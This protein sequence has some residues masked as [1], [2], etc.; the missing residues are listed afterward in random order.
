MSS[1]HLKR[2]AKVAWAVALVPALC[3]FA[4]R[5]DAKKKVAIRLAPNPNQLVE[6]KDLRLF[7]AHAPRKCENYAWAA[8]VEK[9]LAAQQIE[10]RAEGWVDR[11]SNGQ[12]CLDGPLPFGDLAQLITGDYVLDS[13]RKIHIEAQFV[14]G[15]PA[16]MDVLL[17][18]LRMNRPAML[19]WKH[20]PMVLYGIRYDEYR[21]VDGSRI[22]Q[23]RELELE[24]PYATA[25]DPAQRQV[26][27]VGKDDPL[28][29][30]GFMLISSVDRQQ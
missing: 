28:T 18:Q 3:I 20:H 7:A 22:D 21:A 1:A 2:F 11:A 19:V 10:M 14:A 13:G 24:D 5:A 9:M 29:I 23:A 27:T 4:S 6:I 25:A 30:D 17:Q 8:V 15:A 26:F 12:R 16:A